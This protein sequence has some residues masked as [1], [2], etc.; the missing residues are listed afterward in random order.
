MQERERGREHTQGA[1]RAGKGNYLY[2][3]ETCTQYVQ[4]MNVQLKYNLQ[5]ILSGVLASNPN[6]AQLL[7]QIRILESSTM[8]RGYKLE[9]RYGCPL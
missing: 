5:K 7:N 4:G 1:E 9:L 6:H 3:K 8:D 2:L